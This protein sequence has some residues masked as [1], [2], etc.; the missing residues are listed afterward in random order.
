M[1]KGL[2]IWSQLVLPDMLKNDNLTSILV[3]GATA[4]IRGSAKF[5]AFASTKFSLRALT[6]SIAREFGPKGVHAAHFILD[7]L[8]MNDIDKIE[9]QDNGTSMN[10]ND[11][12]DTY[13]FVH[14]QPQSAW[15]QE[16]DL[17]PNMEKF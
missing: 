13:Y 2:F 15:V 12:A 11:I 9:N 5:G 14:Q 10:P 1:L 7:G 3:T 17:R 16:L 4:S 6:Q 8:I